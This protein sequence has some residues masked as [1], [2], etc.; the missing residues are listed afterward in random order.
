MAGSKAPV[1]AAAGLREA[2]RAMASALSFEVKESIV[3]LLQLDLCN[4]LV[5]RDVRVVEVSFEAVLASSGAEGS[6]FAGTIR[7]TLE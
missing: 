1:P 5:S 7:S 6:F 4:Y 2:R 3:A